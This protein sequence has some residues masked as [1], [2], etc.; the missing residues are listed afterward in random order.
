[1]SVRF[2]HSSDWQL[3]VTRRFLSDDA[4]ARWWAARFDAVRELGQVVAKE[5]CEFVVVA[6]D[7]FESNQVDRRTVA[8]AC[9]VLSAIPVPVFLLPGNHDPL[10]AGS[11][12]RSATWRAKK[13]DNVR[14]IEEL[15]RP[16]EVRPGVEVAG[17]PWTSKRPLRDLVAAAANEL[18]PFGGGVRV[19]VAHGAVDVLSPNPDDPA[20]IGVADAEKAIVDGRFHYLAVGDR[21]SITC[22]GTSGRIWYSGTPEAYDFDEVQPGHVIVVDAGPEGVVAT[23]RRVGAWTFLEMHVPLAS[24]GDVEALMRHLESQ[25][26]K[27]RTVVKLRLA[28]TLTIRQ[29]ARLDQILDHARDLFAAVV[30]SETGSELTV[31]PDDS[32]FADLGLAGFAGT[33]VALL[34]ERANAP[35]SESA[36]ARDALALLVRLAGRRT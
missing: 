20:R 8:R 16:F 9:D 18:S 33:A 12:F 21:H 10:D 11:V 15:G 14:V 4:Q 2:L 29:R 22:V 30:H 32:D 25:Q 24:D 13:P 31:V 34:R 35:G 5:R 6:G 17:A 28:G 26:D 36:A 23:P 19:L 27:E 1:M 3:G 7:V